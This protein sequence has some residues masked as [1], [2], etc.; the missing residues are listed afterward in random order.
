MITI[1]SNVP[2][3]RLAN[4]LGNITNDIERSAQRLSTGKRILSAA[5]DPAGIAI[6]NR[7]KTEFG[8][9]GAVQKNLNSGTSLLEV[10]D[11]ALTQASNLIG[12]LRELAVE[13]SNETLSTEQRNALQAVFAELQGQFDDVVNNANIFGQNLVGAAAAN[14]NIQSG[15]NAGDTTTVTGVASDTASLGIDTGTINV[16]SAVNANAAITALDAGLTTVGTNQAVIG[17]QLRSFEIRTDGIDNIR[18]NL[19]SAIDR[20]EAA[21]IAEETTKLALLQT[22]QQLAISALGLV[23]SFPSNALA[24]LR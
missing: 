12:E 7:L 21:D 20:I 23:N 11:S 4:L 17:S 14:V 10:S 18:E 19:Q 1:N 16:T 15:I 24:L 8:S 2:A 6:A 13:A 3:F 22:Q 5:D 9:F